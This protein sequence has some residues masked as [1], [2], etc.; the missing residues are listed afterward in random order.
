LEG[1]YSVRPLRV[2]L[3]KGPK[4]IGFSPFLYL[5]SMGKR[6]RQKDNYVDEIE[7]R[8][9]VYIYFCKHT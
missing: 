5:M 4:L 3:L 9:K 2:A 7:R 6:E 8:Q 1:S